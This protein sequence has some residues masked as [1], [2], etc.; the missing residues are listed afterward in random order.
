V[1]KHCTFMCSRL[2]TARFNPQH[3][4]TVRLCSAE[5]LLHAQ[6]LIPILQQIRKRALGQL[7]AI[8]QQ[9]ELD[10]LTFTAVHPALQLELAKHRHVAPRMQGLEPL[11]DTTVGQRECYRRDRPALPA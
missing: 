4:S 3:R 1:R 10:Y 11:A 6:A 7:Q 5:G 8:V 9:H 2:S